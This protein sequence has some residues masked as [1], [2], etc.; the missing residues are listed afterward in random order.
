LDFSDTVQ[1]RAAQ[2]ILD[3]FKNCPPRHADIL[4]GD[5]N[6]PPDTPVHRLLTCAGGFTDA[7]PQRG[8]HHRFTG[9]P[10]DELPIDWILFKGRIRLLMHRIITKAPGGVYPSDHFPL[11]ARFAWSG[12]P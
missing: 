4:S 6:A 9:V 1:V 7:T 11:N 12:F 3:R 5:F 2:V 10:T 8:T